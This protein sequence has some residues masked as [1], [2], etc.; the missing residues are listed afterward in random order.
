MLHWTPKSV[1]DGCLDKKT[2]LTIAIIECAFNQMNVFNHMVST[3]LGILQQL[4][5]KIKTRI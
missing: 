1:V 2:K 4:F 3:K 5:Q